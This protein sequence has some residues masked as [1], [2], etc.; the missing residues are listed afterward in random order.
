VTARRAAGAALALLAAVAVPRSARA[1]DFVEHAQLTAE[2]ARGLPERARV[3]LRAAIG[4]VR[5]GTRA[6]GG[7]PLCDDPLAS[8]ETGAARDCRPYAALPSLAGDHHATEERLLAALEGAGPLVSGAASSVRKLEANLA[9]IP[10][11]DEAASAQARAD[12]LRAH[13]LYQTVQHGWF[14]EDG[15]VE[16]AARGVSHFQ[17]AD[18]PIEA[19][20]EDLVREGRADRALA[21]AIV[22]HLR[23]LQLASSFR[24]TGRRW[25][26][27]RALAA[28]AFALHFAQDAHAAGHAVMT[29][30]QVTDADGRMRRHDYFGF[31]GVGLTFAL[32]EGP[33]AARAVATFVPHGEASPCWSAL[34]DGNLGEPGA[35]DR[36]RAAASTRVLQLQLAMAIDPS[37]AARWTEEA[38]C[39]AGHRDG[40]ALATTAPPPPGLAI[41]AELL[42]P[43]PPWSLPSGYAPPPGAAG[44]A[45]AAALVAAA[46]RAIARLDGTHRIVAITSDAPD[47]RSG[48]LPVGGLVTE[49][50]I[51]APLERCLPP[52]REVHGADVDPA[53]DPLC[54]SAGIAR[55]RLGTPGSSL[56]RPILAR[57]PVPQAQAATLVGEAGNGRGW[58]WQMELGMQT[59]HTPEGQSQLFLFAAFGVSPRFQDIFPQE[60]SFAPVTFNAGFGPSF[61]LPQ[62]D[63]S[64]AAFLEVRTPIVA[65]LPAAAL[66][67]ALDEV[68][69][70]FIT[71]IAWVPHGARVAYDL[72]RAAVRWDV[73]LFSAHVPLGSTFL[74]H[75]ADLLPAELR[76][77][78]GRDHGLDAWTFGLELVS[79]VTGMF[80][81]LRL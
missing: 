26:L 29:G 58:G 9:G 30:L 25:E 4:E 56:L 52:S 71:E 39:P 7:L 16:L 28:H 78:L 67:L 68:A 6:G 27:A 43:N 74:P 54:R 81:N 36:E 77:R 47:E 8:L 37:I 5:R 35:V 76:L 55:A 53:V 32:A 75:R 31:R 15:Y 12:A 51:G 72:E 45:R 38:A 63:G 18:E 49:G 11:D 62:G 61:L 66:D 50:E 14:S 57:W 80:E 65:V 69:P 13:D 70:A 19:Q 46:Q 22:H 20:L 64:S 2:G 79:G 40:R 34:G 48:V 10:R 21:Q 44:C 33:C 1:F 23:S 73:E 59:A 3:A 17:A 42:D 24:R 60:S 41:A